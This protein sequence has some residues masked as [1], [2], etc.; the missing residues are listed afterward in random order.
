MPMSEVGKMK[1]S[2]KSKLVSDKRKTILYFYVGNHDPVGNPRYGPFDYRFLEVLCRKYN[3]IVAIFATG[4]KVRFTE[5][6]AP[7]NASFLIIRT[8]PFSEKLPVAIRW[9]LQTAIRIIQVSLLLRSLRPALVNG[10]WITRYSGFYCAV[11]NYH[12]FLATAWGGDVLVEP[13]TSAILRA[14]AKYTLKV[15]DAVIVDS[16]TQRKAVIDL[17][18]HPA[19]IYCFP[20]GIDLERFKPMQTDE[21]RRRLGRLKAKIV[22]S[23]RMHFPDYGVET[24]IRAIPSV[25]TKVKDARFIIAGDGP[26]LRHHRAL[27]KELRIEHAVEFMGLVPNEVLPTVLNNADVYVSTS[28]SDGTSGSLLEAIACGLP[29]VVTDIPANREWIKAGEN[30]FLFAP[31]DVAALA[32]RISL[33]LEDDQLR[34]RMSK[35]N[36]QLAHE[37]AD[38]KRNSQ[39]FERCIADLLGDHCS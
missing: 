13:R 24:L 21:L 28:F 1:F 32:D 22:V 11:A 20:W 36:L 10:N 33:I 26:L 16:N 2:L 39:I 8:L 19:K 12:P 9:P 27:A 34:L 17:G 18:C 5:K 7:P 25:S 4:T 14:L 31:G 6:L 29:V 3:V 15:A 37:R 35:Q 30:G 23:T 38:W